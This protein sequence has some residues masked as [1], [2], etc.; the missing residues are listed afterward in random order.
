MEPQNIF[1]QMHGIVMAMQKSLKDIA[2]QRE[3]ESLPPGMR[4]SWS[5]L[6]NH[7]T[8]KTTAAPQIIFQKCAA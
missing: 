4:R 8:A 1:S 7:G 5:L 3:C 2:L 6:D